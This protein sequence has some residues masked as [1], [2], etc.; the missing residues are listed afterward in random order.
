ME[1]IS[2]T[3]IL[4][5]LLLSPCKTAKLSLYQKIEDVFYPISNFEMYRKTIGDIVAL[6]SSSS[7]YYE[8][9]K[10]DDGL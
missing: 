10:V 6:T 8:L 3:I 9:K 5:A 2:N 4:F 1:K 7:L